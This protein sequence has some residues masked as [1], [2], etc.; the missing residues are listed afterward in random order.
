[1]AIAIDQVLVGFANTGANTSVNVTTTAPVAAGG[2]IVVFVTGSQAVT[3]ITDSNGN[4]YAQDKSQANGDTSSI[5]SAHSSSQLA[6]SS[7]IT[8]NYAS[9]SNPCRVVVSSFTGIA[10]SSALDQSNSRTAF[11]EDAWSTSSITPTVANTVVIGFFS[12]GGGSASTSAPDTGWTELY[13]F[14][15][16]NPTTSVYQVV[17]DTT[18]RNPSGTWASSQSGADQIGITVNYKSSAGGTDA[19]VTAAVSSATAAVVAPPKPRPAA[20]FSEINVRM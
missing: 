11:N 12:S 5:W 16:S 20:P 3:S 6:T 18:A 8:V 4:T 19:T 14:N 2:R 9:S 7:T 17:S 15:A 10:T 13:E 1:M